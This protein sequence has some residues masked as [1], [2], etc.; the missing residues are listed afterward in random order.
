MKKE[1]KKLLGLFWF[2]AVISMF[3]LGGC[4]KLANL[5]RQIPSELDS[6]ST[7]LST[8]ELAKEVQVNLLKTYNE[9]NV[10]GSY[11]LAA[12]WV[13]NDLILTKKNKNEY[14]GVITIENMMGTYRLSVDV[15]YDGKTFTWTSKE[16]R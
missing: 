12:M 9:R 16:I 10:A 13:K 7:G 1:R 11:V 8:E 15:I 6:L 14:T 4:T 5:L 2:V 3:T